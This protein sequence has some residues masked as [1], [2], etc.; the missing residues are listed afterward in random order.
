MWLSAFL[1]K[2]RLIVLYSFMHG[3]EDGKW[4]GELNKERNKR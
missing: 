4:N 3:E 2:G 1:G